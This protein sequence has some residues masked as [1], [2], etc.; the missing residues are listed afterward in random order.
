MIGENRV[1]NRLVEEIARQ[2]ETVYMIID[3][4]NK[5]NIQL[6]NEVRDRIIELINSSKR[7]AYMDMLIHEGIF[8]NLDYEVMENSF[9]NKMENMINQFNVQID[10]I[11]P[12]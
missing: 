8:T 10:T 1:E 12:Q 6:K 7:K 11:L 4:E 3:K 2:K 5:T 9:Q